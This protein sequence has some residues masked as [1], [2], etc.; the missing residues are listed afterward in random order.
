MTQQDILKILK[1]ANKPLPSFEIAKRINIS[2]TNTTV[3]LKKL[4][5]ENIVGFQIKKIQTHFKP[6]K[7]YKLKKKEL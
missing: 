4:T 2:R 7:F 1:K 5:K 6:I 3:G